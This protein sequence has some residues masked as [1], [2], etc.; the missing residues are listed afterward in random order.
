MQSGN[1]SRMRAF[2]LVHARPGKA[3]GLAEQIRKIRGITA[4][5]AVTG[6]YDI[7]AVCEVADVKALGDLILD[8]LHRVEG[9]DKTST[10]IVVG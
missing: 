6:D 5:D 8:G 4:A 9:I 10:C 1:D 3:S 2:I 7:I